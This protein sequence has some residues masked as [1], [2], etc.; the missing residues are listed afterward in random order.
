MRIEQGSTVQNVALKAKHSDR[1]A[2]IEFV[3]APGVTVQKTGFQ[4]EKDYQLFILTLTVAANAPL[5]NRSL[6]LK[7]SNGT[8]G[9]ARFGMLEVVRPKT[10]GV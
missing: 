1:N 10:L 3:G 9:P 2:T 6:L 5:G 4:D 8:S 7:N